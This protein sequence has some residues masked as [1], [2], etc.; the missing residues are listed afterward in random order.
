MENDMCLSSGIERR[1]SFANITLSV[2][3]VICQVLHLPL[4]F[5]SCE[6]T[7]YQTTGR[8]FSSS[9]QVVMTLWKWGL[10]AN[11]ASCCGGDFQDMTQLHFGMNPFFLEHNL[12]C[13]GSRLL[14]WTGVCS[15][16]VLS[17]IKTTVFRL[18]LAVCTIKELRQ[19]QRKSCH[20]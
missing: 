14:W 10:Y 3:S 19:Q 16:L 11:E 20:D 2:F 12:F 5:S 4:Q 7:I 13:W 15:R 18:L 1:H 6:T 17:S 8:S 9:S